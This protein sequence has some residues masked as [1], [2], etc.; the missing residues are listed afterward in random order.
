MEIYKPE[1]PKS[2][3]YFS[4]VRAIIESDRF[5]TEEQEEFAGRGDKKDTL[6]HSQR[7]TNL[8]YLLG[9]KKGFSSDE[10]KLFVEACLLHDI[11]KTETPLKYLT[12]PSGKFGSKDMQVVKKHPRRGYEILKHHN[13]SPRVYYPVLLHHEFQEKPYPATNADLLIKLQKIEDID[14][15]NARLLAMLDVFDICAFGRP[16]VKIEPLTLGQVREKMMAQFTEEG[17]GEIIDF[18]ISQYEL[19]KELGGD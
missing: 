18:L 11:G 3:I 15:D 14:I 19:I 8:G 1:K 16:Y 12:R 9:K 2:K 4:E 17:D 10:I 13:R 6:R 7:I 5:L